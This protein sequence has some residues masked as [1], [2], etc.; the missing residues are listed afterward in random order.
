MVCVVL[1]QSMMEHLQKVNHALSTQVKELSD[2][3]GKLKDENLMIKKR[4][5]NLSP[6]KQKRSHSLPPSDVP[7]L[8]EHTHHI[9]PIVEGR[10][11]VSE[12]EHSANITSCH[13]YMAVSLH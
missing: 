6:G 8:K 13:M 2:E 5:Q 1:L 12:V 3:V 9:P 7:N 10:N 11:T 4:Q